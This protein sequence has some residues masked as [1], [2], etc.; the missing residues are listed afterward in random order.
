MQNSD[1]LPPNWQWM[2]T[3]E[4]RLLR[5][6]CLIRRRGGM[7]TDQIGGR[8]TWEPRAIMMAGAGISMVIAALSEKAGWST[9]IAGLVRLYGGE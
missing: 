9:V 8:R 5:L 6:E 7:T 3:V 4:R 1:G 2:L